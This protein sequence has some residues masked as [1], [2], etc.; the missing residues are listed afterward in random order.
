[1]LSP[2]NDRGILVDR[3]SDVPLQR[4]L[5]SSLREAI[6][7]GRMR[8]G[9]R[10]LSSREMQIHLGVSRNTI[11]NAIAQLS[12]DGY[13]D[14]IQG[15]GTFVAQVSHLSPRSRPAAEYRDETLLPSQRAARSLGASG[16]A[17]NL[18]G[19][20]P[21]R[22]GIPDLALFPA[23]MFGRCLQFSAS[24]LGSID[25]PES[26]GDTGLREAIVERLRQTRGIDCTVEQVLIAGG[27]QTA[28]AL[29]AHVMLEQGGAVV[30]EE[31]G[32]PSARAAFLAAG[33]RIT[34]VKVDRDGID[35]S[36]LAGRAGTLVHVTPSHQY[37][38]GAVLSLE[39]RFA[40]LEWARKHDGWI[41]EDDYDSEFKY[42][43][44][45]QPALF[46]L[47]NGGRVIYVGTFS[48]ALSPAL[49]VAYVVVPRSLRGA[50]EAEHTVLGGQPST[51][52]QKALAKFIADG[53]FSRH[54]TKMRKVYDERRLAAAAEF[55]RA[56]GAAAQVWDSKAGLHFVVR[57]SKDVSAGDLSERA[58]RAGY[59]IPA[60]STY[61]IGECDLN[62]V[63]V[64]F[65]A[66]SIQDGKQAIR[67]LVRLA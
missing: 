60:L 25:Y 61:C 37:P 34:P 62:A 26:N 13:L 8:A 57:F 52:I 53:H 46:G 64:G 18:T 49:R 63:I 15:V 20:V 22:P 36:A 33:A 28:F 6:L 30:T 66:T 7:S 54:V 19:A 56:F 35:V 12:A 4:Q 9:D 24:S 42:K 50:F 27:A 31:P 2:K 67:D 17:S 44:K 5:E 51:I 1:M 3:S 59:V 23:A 40:L 21:F 29:I 14:C 10:I 58:E 55:R 45:A 32:Y 47:G 16:F 48:K 11:V 43:E 38:T 39:R 41:V 65:A